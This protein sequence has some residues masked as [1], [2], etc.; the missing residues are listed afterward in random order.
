MNEFGLRPVLRKSGA[1]SAQGNGTAAGIRLLDFWEW[2]SSD[3]LSNTLRGRFAEFLV[4]S[5][6]GVADR[7]RIEWDAIDLA[8]LTGIKVEVKSSAYLQSWKG[9]PSY[10]SFDIRHRRAW[11]WE[12]N[13]YAASPTRSADENLK[14]PW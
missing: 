14:K 7:T 4:A 10:I 8:S 12:R 6:L 3:L 2:S 11:E 1:E 5:A 13:S 9:N